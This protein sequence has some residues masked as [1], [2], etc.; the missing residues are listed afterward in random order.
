VREVRP[1]ILGGSQQA[2]AL[3]IAPHGAARETVAVI[4]TRRGRERTNAGGVRRRQL[5]TAGDSGGIACACRCP[6]MSWCIRRLVSVRLRASVA[7][8]QR[9]PR[10]RDEAD[11]PAGRGPPVRVAARVGSGRRSAPHRLES[12]GPARQS[13][14]APVRGGAA[15]AGVAR[16]RYG[17]AHDRGCRR[18]RGTARLRGPGG[19]RA[20]PMPP[21]STTTMS[22]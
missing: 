8:A 12:D 10:S 1:D 20:G 16:A 4:P 21:R 19:A 6:G 2:R 5:R 15:P 13:H 7:D 18:R 11:S 22:A 14:H 9:R 3:S 17:T